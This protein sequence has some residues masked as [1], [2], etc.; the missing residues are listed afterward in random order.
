MSASNK[1]KLRREQDVEKLTEKQLAEKKEAK[2]LKI[3][4]VSVCAILALILVAFIGIIVANSGILHRNTTAMKVGDHKISS[5][6]LNY[7]YIDTVT[8]FAN[9]YGNYIGMFGLNPKKPLDKQIYS[10][11]KVKPGLTTS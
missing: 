8:A 9:Q 10:E 3:Y 4:T 6:E 7:N 11:E 2:K 1:K 5:V